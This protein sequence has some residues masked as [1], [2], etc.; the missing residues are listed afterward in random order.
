LPR[1]TLI[2]VASEVSEARRPA[3]WVNLSFL[4]EAE[5]RCSTPLPWIGVVI[6]AAVIVF[7]IWDGLVGPD[8]V[9]VAVAGIAIGGFVLWGFCFRCPTSIELVERRVT[10]KSIAARRQADVADLAR[11]T[12]PITG[13]A[14]RFRFRRGPSLYWMGTRSSLRRVLDAVHDVRPDLQ[15]Q[16]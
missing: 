10:F 5:P 3:D 6:V 4:R 15:V 9:G 14:V 16:P 8:G 7:D 13:G 12:R 2:E 11:V 1:L